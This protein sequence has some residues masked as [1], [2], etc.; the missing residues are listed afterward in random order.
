MTHTS[1]KSKYAVVYGADVGVRESKGKRKRLF[2]R[3]TGQVCSV[4]GCEVKAKRGAMCNIHYRR[5]LRSGKVELENRDLIS[6]LTVFAQG[7]H[8]ECWLWPKVTRK[9]YG[10]ARYKGKPSLAHRAAWE[11]L[12][13]AIQ[14]DKQVNHT[15][16]VRNCVN[17]RHLYLGTQRE[18][19]R[20]KKEAGRTGKRKTYNFYEYGGLILSA[21]Q[22]AEKASFSV[23]TFRK[24]IKRGWS[25]EET[26]LTPYGTGRNHDRD[27]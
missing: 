20:D 21:K 26:I 23:A 17:P 1:H 13:G 24:R 6:R 14:D 7:S 10:S 22:W 27:K 12:V 11:T 15:C 25:L 9:G 4:N 16:H 5:L 2:R 3:Y 8:D 18:N 19:M